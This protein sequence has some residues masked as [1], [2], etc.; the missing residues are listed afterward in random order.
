[1][2]DN[3][4]GVGDAAHADHAFFS[5]LRH[6]DREGLDR[7]LA[8]DFV[9]VDV[10]RGAQIERDDFLNAVASGAIRFDAIDVIEQVLRYY[11]D[12][13]IVVGCTEMRGRISD[14]SW[15]VR[16]RYTHVFVLRDGR[17][18]LANAQGTPV[19]ET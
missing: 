9:I 13:C 8:D 16:S 19:A 6:S 14:T 3:E 15:Q 5:F 1:M 10:F 7:M 4:P 17:W 2:I 18:Q 11:G 12:A